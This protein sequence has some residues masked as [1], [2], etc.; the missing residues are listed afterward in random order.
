MPIK[1]FAVFPG[2]GQQWQKFLQESI[3]T[4]DNY[5]EHIV[6]DLDALPRKIRLV[7]VTDSIDGYV[8]AYRDQLDVWRRFTDGSAVV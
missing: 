7:F 5:P 3:V 4:A 8:P 6:D 2:T 1:P